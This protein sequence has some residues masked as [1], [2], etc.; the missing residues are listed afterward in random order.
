[1]ERYISSKYVKKIRLLVTNKCSRNCSYCHNEGMS[2]YPEMELNPRDIA[3]FLRNLR[4]YSSRI[5]LSGGEPF[6]YTHLEQLTE[7]LLIDGFDITIITAN[8]Q[9]EKLTAIGSRI[10]AIHYS[11]HSVDHISDDI[12]NIYWVFKTFPNIRITLN[13]PLTDEETLQHKW[14]EIYSLAKKVNANIQLI[15]LF[16]FTASRGIKWSSR[17][18]VFVRFL[19]EQSSFLEATERETRLITKDLIKIDLLDIP[20]V[21]SGIEFSDGACLNNTDITIDPSLRVSLCR[22]T[23]SAISLYHEGK[24]R[25]IEQVIYEAIQASCNNCVFGQI[26]YPF[27]KKRIQRYASFPHYTWPKVN[28][29]IIGQFNHSSE[30]DLSYYGK[31]GAV[32]QLENAFSKQIGAVYTLAVN[33]GTTAIFLACKALGLKK[34][35][36]IIIP[37]ATFPSLLPAILLSGATIR[38]CDIDSITGNISL[39]SFKKAITPN[40]RAVLVTHLWGIPAE[41]S[42][43]KDICQKNGIALIEDGSHAYGASINGQRVGT[44]GDIACFS[45]QAN[46]AV[47]SGEGGLF[48]TSDKDLYEKAVVYS[49]SVD[50][51]FDCVSTSKNL[52]YWSTGLGSKLKIHP[53]GARIALSS[54]QNLEHVIRCREDRLS[55]L[56][57]TITGSDVFYK[58]VLPNTVK[59]TYYTYK[60]I[61]Q[62]SFIPYRNEI[63]EFMIHYGLEA[64]I[65]SF[66]PAYKHSICRPG[67]PGIANGHDLFP[68]SEKYYNR[69]ISLPAFVYEPAALVQYYGKIIKDAEQF[70]IDKQKNSILK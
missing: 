29:G 6:E 18:D 30:R 20:C 47:F 54:L 12:P 32:F 56:D 26:S 42:S 41:I 55:I 25:R 21:C 31:S 50:R 9:R 28:G 45:M 36:E 7:L 70:I 17:W 13:V 68:Q 1:M 23:D 22:W 44:F 27:L 19:Q 59:R 51:I 43:M 66:I 2:A 46:K 62:D 67:Q 60:L 33:S 14:S 4:C 10:K 63:L 16:S 35:D 69:I 57:R 64:G 39:E 49:A 37:V 15:R 58:V 38:F 61:V 40:T 11:I 52:Q 34:A 8:L 48:V 3:P 65:T 5:V 53:L 24:P